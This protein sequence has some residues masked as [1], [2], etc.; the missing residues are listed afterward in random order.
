MSVTSV[1]M[2]DGSTV[3][4]AQL[5]PLCGGHDR[6]PD[7]SWSDGPAS[8]ESYAVTMFDP[9]APFG[10]AWHWVA[11][12]IASSI[13]ALPEGLPA[14]SPLA[15]Q[16]A[17]SSFQPHYDGPC[18]PPGLPHRYTVTVYALDTASLNLPD[19]ADNATARAAIDAHTLATAQLTATY[20]AANSASS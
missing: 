1:A 12:D 16:A 2:P 11:F 10:G 20:P 14:A 9:D 17:N 18:P 15:R 7:L 13:T 3:A 19:G 5:L 8:A 4:A 6:S